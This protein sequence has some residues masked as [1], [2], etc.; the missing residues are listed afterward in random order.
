MTPR[1]LLRLYPR[2]WRER[3][4]DEVLALIEQSAGGGWRLFFD[5]ARGCVGAWLMSLLG[6]RHPSPFLINA[7][8]LVLWTVGVVSMAGMALWLQLAPVT[9]RAVVA[10]VALV[11]VIVRHLQTQDRTDTGALAGPRALS[12]SVLLILVVLAAGVVMR[13]PP[14]IASLSGLRGWFEFVFIDAFRSGA[15]LPLIWLLPSFLRRLW[16]SAAT[17]LDRDRREPRQ[18]S[19]LGLGA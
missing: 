13:R 9:W 17:E 4:G 14:T 10:F 19:F 3:Y 1:T 8:L 11:V 5:L 12:E 6:G 7:L 16:P 15:A 18:T 2:A